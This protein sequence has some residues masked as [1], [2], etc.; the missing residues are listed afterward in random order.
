LTESSSTASTQPG[1]N[2]PPPPPPGLRTQFGRTKDAALGLVMAHVDLAK[3]EFSE[4]I[5]EIKRAMMLGSIALAFVFVAATILTVG[6]VLWLDEWIFGSMGWGVLHGT[7]VFIGLAVL[8]LLPIFDFG[9]GRFFAAVVVGAVFGIAVGIVLFADWRSIA[10]STISTVV[11]EWRAVIAAAVGG[12]IV[13][14]VLGIICALLLRGRRGVGIFVALL[15]LG[16]ILGW[17]VGALASTGA[18]WNI[19]G[20]VGFAVFFLLIPIFSAILVFRHGID[21]EALKDRFLPDQTIDTTKETIEWVRA[22]TPLG[23]KS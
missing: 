8:V 5:G 16:A 6:S 22:Q 19:A 4:I 18:G 2:P 9:W 12:A 3:A 23:R 7:E 20:G 11:P 14:G 21:T 15:V 13:L 10:D 17:I 1:S